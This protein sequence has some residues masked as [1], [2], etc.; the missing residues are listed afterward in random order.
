M[1]ATFPILGGQR[2]E[3]LITSDGYTPCTVGMNKLEI[4]VKTEEGEDT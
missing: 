1:A 3:L 4:D 2:V